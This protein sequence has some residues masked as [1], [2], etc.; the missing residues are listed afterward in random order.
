M[1]AAWLMPGSIFILRNETNAQL[2]FLNH[3]GTETRR[4]TTFFLSTFICQLTSLFEPPRFKNATN[5]QMFFDYN[6]YAHRELLKGVRMKACKY[7]FPYYSLFTIHSPLSTVIFQ[8]TLQS[9]QRP[10]VND[11]RFFKALR[12]R[13][14]SPGC[15]L[16]RPA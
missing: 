9:K 2:F 10:N 6:L 15:N 8:P 1:N 11:Q 13:Q 14:I 7:E 16:R 3:I 5:A 4:C 12:G